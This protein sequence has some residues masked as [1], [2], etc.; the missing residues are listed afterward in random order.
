MTISRK[1][2]F[3][4]L[5]LIIS[6]FVLSVLMA[7]IFA[8]QNVVFAVS[9]WHY[10]TI[11]ATLPSNV[12]AGFKDEVG[13]F[14]NNAQDAST[15]TAW[16]IL[17]KSANGQVLTAKKRFKVGNVFGNL[18]EIAEG[19]DEV[20]WKISGTDTVIT[21][22]TKFYSASDITL[23]LSVQYHQY[24]VNYKNCDGATNNN[25][26]YHTI[27]TSTSIGSVSKPGYDFVGWTTDYQLAPVNPYV[28]SAD[29]KRNVTLTANWRAHTYQVQ[30]NANGGVG[31]ME[32]QSFEYGRKQ[33][34]AK[35]DFVNSLKNFVGWATTSSGQAIYCDQA[36]V[37]DLTSTNNG[38]FNL[39]AVWT[40]ENVYKV[41]FNA[42]GGGGEMN[43]QPFA[44]NETKDLSNLL[45]ARQG[46]TFQHWNTQADGKG[47]D[48][49]DGQTVQNLIDENNGTFNLYAIWTENSYIVNFDANG[50]E[51]E[52]GQ[53]TFRYTELKSLS[54]N[55]FRNS[56]LEFACWNTKSDGTGD[57]YKDCQLVNRLAQD[58]ELTLYAIWQEKTP[59]GLSKN[60]IIIIAI[61][62]VVLVGIVVTTILVVK[63]M[64][65]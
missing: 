54:K 11:K 37:S 50:G 8:A 55:R 51:G 43:S 63:K 57:A 4:F 42:N 28:I 36:Y 61:A 33:Q 53:Q 29:E 52:M 19:Y 1:R 40:D 44:Y 41:K 12:S 38:V 47:E 24:S 65:D 17:S 31:T 9:E 46:F 15:G 56:N 14:S 13:L 48:F 27:R 26:K 21:P 35:L 10:V 30:F 6:A 3:S 59:R 58:G 32:N 25:A 60:A 2:I 23:V 49:E 34:L 20:E 64:N 62:S 22:T 39:Y 7:N 5:V 18:P 45:F 16:L